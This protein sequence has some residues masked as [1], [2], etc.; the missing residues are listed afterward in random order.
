[1]LKLGSQ[2]LVECLAELASCNKRQDQPM[3]SRCACMRNTCS[4]GSVLLVSRCLEMPGSAT[5]QAVWELLPRHH[6]LS[7]TLKCQGRDAFPIISKTL[8]SATYTALV[9]W[10]RLRDGSDSFAHT[11][12]ADS[13]PTNYYRNAYDPSLLDGSVQ[14]WTSLF[15]P[16]SSYLSTSSLRSSLSRAVDGLAAHVSCTKE[17]AQRSIGWIHLVI[18]AMSA[19]LLAGGNFCMRCVA[20]PNRKQIDAAHEKHSS[21]DVGIPSLTN[22]LCADRKRRISGLILGCSSLPLHLW[23]VLSILISLIVIFLTR[24]DHERSLT[25]GGHGP[26][27]KWT[28]LWAGASRSVKS[29]L[30]WLAYAQVLFS[31]T[32][33]GSFSYNS[34]IFST[35][36]A[37][38]FITLSAGRDFLSPNITQFN[39]VPSAVYSLPPYT[40]QSDSI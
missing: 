2:S 20:A 39:L 9:K 23:W 36:S 11:A 40:S 34:V 18:N 13:P 10:P 16:P 25:F 35:I 33:W 26:L 1:M 24:G 5:S 15:S 19:I 32:D 3:L 28:L 27:K 4:C 37:N 22:I 8:F 31:I 14:S 21:L 38:N 30:P 6:K 17:T 12:M 29:R 7:D